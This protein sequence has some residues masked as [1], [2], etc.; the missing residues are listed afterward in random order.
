MRNP[1]QPGD[2]KT[3]TVTV[4]DAM[5]A[6]FEAGLVHPVYGT[7]ALARDAEWACRLFVLEMLE[8]GEEGIGT[9]VSVNH[10]SPAP[11]GAKVAITARLEEVVR[12]R[13]ECTWQA[14]LGERLVAEGKQ[15]QKIIDKARFD[16]VLADLGG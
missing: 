3:C 16:A 6:R 14:H 15:T 13:V 10:V 9:F 1:F 11:L 5:L 12:N 8:P 2:L 4:T 7:F